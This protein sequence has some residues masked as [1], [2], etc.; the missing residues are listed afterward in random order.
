[1]PV[2]FY[3][4][5]RPNHDPIKQANYFCAL[6]NAKD[7]SLPPVCDIETTGGLSRERVAD[8]LKKFLDRVEA[9]TTVKPIIYTRSSFFNYAVAPRDY[10]KRYNLWIAR[11]ANVDEP[12]GNTGD[13]PYVQ[14]RD[15]NTW[16]FWQY[17][18]DGNG[19]GA[20]YGA[21]SKSIDKNVFNG[22]IH[23][24]AAYLGF[25]IPVPPP[26]DPEIVAPLKTVEVTA[27]AL[28]TRQLP[29][30][31]SKDLGELVKGSKVPVTAVDGEW[32]LVKGW[33]H[34][35]YTKPA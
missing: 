23:A 31:E 33:I 15:W 11:Y 12:W 28:N 9:V 6:I 35:G 17:S 19:E 22:D 21:Q 13:A 34:G 26:T 1:M 10:W 2:G 20:K 24:F 27:N 25:Q 3:W 29:T 8:S 7:F 32:L 16:F 5:F 30:A 18:A 4:Y 14:P